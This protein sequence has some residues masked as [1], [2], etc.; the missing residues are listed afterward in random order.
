MENIKILLIREPPQHTITVHHKGNE[1][2]T[3][4]PSDQHVV[5]LTLEN[6]NILLIRERQH[7]IMVQHKGNKHITVDPSDQHVAK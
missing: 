4:D 2:I 6:I 1:H 3:A 5:S 7:T